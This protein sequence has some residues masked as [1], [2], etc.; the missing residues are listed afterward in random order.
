MRKIAMQYMCSLFS[1]LLIP[2]LCSAQSN[3][4]TRKSDPIATV[5]GQAITEDA[6][7][8]LIVEFSD[9]QCLLLRPG[10]SYAKERAGQA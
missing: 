1:I 8:R 2:V 7:P 4:S 6:S 3:A 5:D 10:G 9:F